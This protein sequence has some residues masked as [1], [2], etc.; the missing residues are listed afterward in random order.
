MQAGNCKNRDDVTGLY[1]GQVEAGNV[2][3]VPGGFLDTL[4]RLPGPSKKCDHRNRG[5]LFTGATSPR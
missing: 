5:A 2:I 1:R 4:A 3:P